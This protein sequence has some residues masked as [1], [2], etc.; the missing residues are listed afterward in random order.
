MRSQ[1]HKRESVI[2]KSEP[3]LPALEPFFAFADP[4]PEPMLLV[5]PNGVVV[6]A[7]R[8][9]CKLFKKAPADLQG[10]PL[11]QMVVDPPGTVDHYLGSCLHGLSMVTGKLTIVPE[12]EMERPCRAEG[13]VIGARAK[14]GRDASNSE[15]MVLVRLAPDE[16]LNRRFTHLQERIDVLSDELRRRRVAE[17]VLRLQGRR[18]VERRDELAG[19][20]NRTPFMLTRCTRELRYTFVSDAY[21]AMFGLTAGQIQGRPIADVIGKD[22]FAILEPRIREALAGREVRYEARL[23]LKGV[24]PRDLAVVYTPE[25]DDGGEVTGWIASILDVTERKRNELASARLAAIVESSDDAIISK[26]LDGVITTWNAGAE[27]TFGY[28]AAEA[29]GQPITLIIPADRRDEEPEILERIRRGEPI[30]HFE[31]VRR[32]KDGALLDISLSVSPIRDTHGGV[33]GA[34]KIARDINERKRL[35]GTERRRSEQVLRLAEIATR[36]NTVHDVRSIVGLVNEEARELIGADRSACSITEEGRWNLSVVSY[37]DRRPPHETD[38]EDR[39]PFWILA[40]R[41]GRPLRMTRAQMEAHPELQGLRPRCACHPDRNWLAVRLTG[42]RDGER[43]VLELC[44][45]HDGDFTAEDEAILVQLS[46]MASVAMNNARLV[47]NLRD[48][49]RRKDEFLAT[50]AHELRNPLAPLRHGL[51]VMKLA[52]GDEAAV[53]EAR[54]MMDRQLDQLVRLIDDLMDV[55]RISR[56]KIEL[57]RQRVNLARVVQQAVETSQ[58][59]IEAA[60][61]TLRVDIPEEPIVVDAD[62]T[63]LAQVV[64]NLLNNAAKYTEPGGTITLAAWRDGQQVVLSVQDTGIGIPSAMLPRVFD[65]F[66]QVD[67]SLEKAQ[68]GVG[69][70]LSIV[71][72]LVELHAGTVE[73]HSA[74][75]GKGS[76]FLVR[77]PVADQPAAAV[78]EPSEALVAAHGGLRILVADDNVDSAKS[79]AVLL[80][81]MGNEVHTAHDGCEAVNAALRMHPDLALLDIGMPR[82]NGYEACRRIR[83]QPWA[84]H[85]VM[86]ALTGWGQMEDVRRSEQAGFDHH[87]VKPVE[88]Q[89]LEKLLASCSRSA[90]EFS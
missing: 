57:R 31:T 37:A 81:I 42:L 27:R 22:A 12:G 19:I 70:G 48:S 52:S 75:H 67:R 38:V 51:Q 77:L 85:T 89:A 18:H 24:R 80:Q 5:R 74:G 62:E 3:F 30:E 78:D 11:G 7:N 36:L 79:L 15:A 21:A 34:A 43:G 72:A 14:R 83:E 39:T 65:L 49:N 87:L 32:R 60:R 26:D 41:S 13:M 73:A 88:P 56:G 50:L 64:S 9:A 86:V 63:R 76:E 17:D 66:T 2:S 1:E 8:A 47:E 33:I 6:A 71:K 29:I 23:P 45:K 69:V 20:I 40:G 28:S 10:R 53:R 61:H 35:E 58:P 44:D 68:G 55:S 84:Q 46:H 59:L 4:L 90:P 16:G 54:G 25:H 82:L